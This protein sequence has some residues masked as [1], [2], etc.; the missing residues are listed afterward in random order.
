MTRL[1]PGGIYQSGIKL[2]SDRKRVLRSFGDRGPVGQL[3]G[4]SGMECHGKSVCK[5]KCTSFI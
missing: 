2:L 5:C 4:M 1:I 3:S